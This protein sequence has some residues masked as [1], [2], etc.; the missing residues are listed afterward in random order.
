MVYLLSKA[1]NCFADEM[2]NQ[3]VKKK[4][5]LLTLG[6]ALEKIQNQSVSEIFNTYPED[7]R[8]K[9]LAIRAL[10]FKL[11]IETKDIGELEETLK[12]GEPSYLTSETHSGSTIRLSWK[13]SF[14]EQ[15]A[16]YF[17]C[18]TTLISTFKDIYGDL[19]KYEGNRSIYFQKDEKIPWEALSGCIIM[20]LTYHLNK[21]WR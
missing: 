21:D 10:I 13:K 17:N 4:T 8:E 7:I 6:V 9:L 5:V 1:L 20:A 12:W 15:Y 16:I 18:K 2:Q 14:P 11:A 3:S 19:F